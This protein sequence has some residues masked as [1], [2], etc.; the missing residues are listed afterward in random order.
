MYKFYPYGRHYCIYRFQQVISYIRVWQNN[1]VF[2]CS[3][4]LK[5]QTSHPYVRKGKI[6]LSNSCNYTSISNPSFLDFF[7]SE[8]IALLACVITMEMFLPILPLHEKQ[9]SRY[10]YLKSGSSFPFLL[11]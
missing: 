2:I 10:I 7:N 9:K 5:P 11:P 6:I 1:Q 4:F 8:N 3:R